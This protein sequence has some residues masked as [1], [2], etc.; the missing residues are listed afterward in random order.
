MIKEVKVSGKAIRYDLQRRNVKNIN[1][2]VKSDGSI[3]VSANKSVPQYIIDA[4]IISK[5]DFIFRA[6]ERLRNLAEK[7]KIQCYS[8]DELKEL[9]LKL[10][11]TT[12]PYYEARGIRRPEIK[13]R[14]MVSRWGSCRPQRGILTF[15]TNLIYAPFECIEYVVLHEFTHFLQA[16]H[17]S[18]FYEELAKV[19]PD[20]KEKRTK[21]KEIVIR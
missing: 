10:C 20:W 3:H 6:A 9:I 17:S 14:K 1:L 4:F 11:E 18:R 2:R 8:E 16:N 13:F 7:P 15:N 5:A 19:C 12:Y 21:L